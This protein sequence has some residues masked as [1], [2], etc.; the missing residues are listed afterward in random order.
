VSEV[1]VYAEGIFYAS[2]CAPSDMPGE[3]VAAEVQSERPAGTRNGWQVSDDETFRTG[4]PMPCACDKDH[5][6]KHWLLEA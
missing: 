4:E 5:R 2:V 3:Q 1:I 6:R